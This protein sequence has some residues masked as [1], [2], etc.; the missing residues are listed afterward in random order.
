[1]NHTEPLH[2]RAAIRGLPRPNCATTEVPLG[3]ATALRW[4]AWLA[5]EGFPPLERI[6]VK[7]WDGAAYVMPITYAPDRADA[8]A[9]GIALRWAE[10]LR[11]KA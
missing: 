10:W 7:T 11:S 9:H 5:A 3:S 6:G 1:M 8:V 4:D 2:P